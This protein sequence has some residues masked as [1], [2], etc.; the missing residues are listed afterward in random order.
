[1][2]DMRKKLF[3]K[4][5]DDVYIIC[6][7]YNL[8]SNDVNM[9]FYI[10][11]GRDEEMQNSSAPGSSGATAS[12]PFAT[13]IGNDAPSS[14]QT[15]AYQSITFMQ[16]YERYSFEELRLADYL[17]GSTDCSPGGAFSFAAG[18]NEPILEFTSKGFEVRPV[19]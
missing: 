5:I 11:P 2:L 3:T 17:A 16:P 9:R 19:K 18:Q 10:S 14:S 1:M 6:R 12:T 8:L 7:V 13:T 15:N 4:A